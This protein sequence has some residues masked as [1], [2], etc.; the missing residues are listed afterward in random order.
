M[1]PIR[2]SMRAFTDGDGQPGETTNRS[3]IMI[4]PWPRSQRC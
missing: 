2:A 4:W 1:E 3:P